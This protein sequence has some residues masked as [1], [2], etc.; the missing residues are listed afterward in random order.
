MQPLFLLV[1]DGL[2]ERSSLDW[3]KFFL[4]LQLTCLSN[5]VAVLVTDRPAHWR[6]KCLKRGVDTFIE[7]VIERYSDQELDFALA[8]HD[9][10]VSKVPL[11]I[12]ELIRIPRYCDVVARHFHEIVASGDFTKEHVLFLEAG[13]RASRPSVPT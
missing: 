13:S 10:S 9:I 6:P 11:A 7:I 5:H 2:N 12:R 4:E 8:R 1:I 3:P